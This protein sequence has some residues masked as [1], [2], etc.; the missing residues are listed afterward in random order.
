MRSSRK[1]IVLRIS[2][3]LLVEMFIVFAQLLVS[4]DRFGR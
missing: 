3:L 4:I 1:I 2:A